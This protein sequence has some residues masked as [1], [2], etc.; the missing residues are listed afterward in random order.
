MTTNISD[1]P[2]LLA[3]LPA[4]DARA[5]RTSISMPERMFQEAVKHQRRHGYSTF[6]DYLQH[7]VRNDL[8]ATG[9]DK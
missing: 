9:R 6:S 2:Q 7:L 1:P 8:F 5:H 3:I 4:D